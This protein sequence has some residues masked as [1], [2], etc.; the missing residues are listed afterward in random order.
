MIL[1]LHDD[2]GGVTVFGF[3]H[4]SVVELLQ[5]HRL[6]AGIMH[7]NLDRSRCACMRGADAGQ[8]CMECGGMMI[9]TGTCHTCTECGTTGGCG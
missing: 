4:R 5:P 7:D 9:R 2:A 8:V 3:P 1:L 6:G